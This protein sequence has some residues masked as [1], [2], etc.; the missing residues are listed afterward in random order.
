MSAILADALLMWRSVQA[1]KVRLA[2]NWPTTW[3]RATR[4]VKRLI[5]E[6]TIGR[7][8]EVK[9]RN[10]GSMGPMSY[11]KPEP[12][13]P[14]K[15]AEWWHQ[16]AA[17]GGALLDYTCYGACLA[18]WLIGTPAVAA[19]GLRANLTSDY[20]DADDNAIIT[21]RFPAAIAVL[22]A[23]WTTWNPVIPNLLVYGER[24]ALMVNLRPGADEQDNSEIV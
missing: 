16:S 12:P 19:N 22:E 9:W 11:S 23:T 24:G 8:L 21:V 13:G 1:N 18:R 2:I 10:G 14:V 4:T 7:V 20:G 6:G 17:G 15:G 5:E 3:S